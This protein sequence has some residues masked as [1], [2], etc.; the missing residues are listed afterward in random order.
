MQPIYNLQRDPFKSG[1]NPFP[2][3]SIEKS[4]IFLDRT[5]GVSHQ[6]EELEF[7]NV[8][9]K[10]AFIPQKSQHTEIEGSQLSVF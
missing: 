2:E 3:G 6:Q 5:V 4:Q 8:L 1:E 9:K 7:Q 10:Q